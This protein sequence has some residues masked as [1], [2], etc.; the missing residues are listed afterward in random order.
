MKRREL[1]PRL[2]AVAIWL[3]FHLFRLMPLD[4]ASAVGGWIGRSIGYRL[5][6]TRQARHNLQRVF[7]DMPA[8]RREAILRAMWD[9]LGRTAA[10]F[11]HLPEFGFGPGQR[12]EVEGRQYIE[13]L[14]DDGGPGLF[15]GGHLANWELMGLCAVRTDL[16]LH[17]IYRAPNNPRLEW[18]YRFGRDN[19]GVQLIPKGAAGARTALQLLRRGEHIGM[20]IDQKMNDGIAVPFFGIEAMTAPALATFALKYDCPVVA[21][22]VERL[23]GAR[24]R[25]VLDPPIRFDNTGNRHADILAAMTKVNALLEGWIRRRPE[26]WLWLHHRWPD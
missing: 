22:H 26:Q 24:F 11:P 23:C 17:L 3:V 21:A 10:E 25:M 19:D 8:E 12:V 5:P 20:L 18:V 16:P 2:E 9:N 14:R 1:P 7:P 13:Q 6:L 15:F 4:L